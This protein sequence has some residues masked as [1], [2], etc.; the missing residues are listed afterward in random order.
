MVVANDEG[1]ILVLETSLL[2]FGELCKLGLAN[3][4]DNSSVSLDER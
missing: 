3:D 1:G 2:G 4:L